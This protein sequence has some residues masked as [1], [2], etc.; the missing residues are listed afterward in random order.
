MKMAK[1]LSAVAILGALASCSGGGGG[2]TST[3]GLYSSPYI[4]ATGFVNALND[5]DGAPL[6]DESEVVLYTDETIRSG[7]AGED[8]WFVIYDALE[9]EY[10][11]ISLQYVRSLQYYD[12]YSN[13]FSTAE[14]FRN[15][16]SDDIFFGFEN[17]DLGGDDYEDVVLVGGIFYGEESGFAYEDEVETTDVNLMAGEKE[18]VET[19]QKVMG[20]SLAYSVSPEAAYSIA[21]LGKKV[22]SMIK[23]GASQEELTEEDQAVLMQDLENITGVTLEEVV[24]AGITEEGKQEVYK[25]VANKL[26]TTAQNVEDKILPELFGLQK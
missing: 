18:R 25:K 7:L 6:F 22:E 9:D 10:K 11:A 23:K 17:G 4:T 26:G 3:Y 21:S 12:Y 8:D 14:E 19:A 20:I 5:V 1:T 2:G 24:A 15:I 16:E 13:N